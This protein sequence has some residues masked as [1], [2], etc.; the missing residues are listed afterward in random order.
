MSG[1]G[2]QLTALVQSGKLVDYELLNPVWTITQ[3]H[4]LRY[5]DSGQQTFLLWS[6]R[7][8]EAVCGGKFLKK[9]V[10]SLILLLLAKGAHLDFFCSSLNCS[11]I[12]L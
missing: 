9:I 2:N 12:L 7:R 1:K 6:A 11:V 4:N 5:T 10:Q 3:G 8:L